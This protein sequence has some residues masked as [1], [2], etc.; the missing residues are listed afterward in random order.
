MAAHTF[1]TEYGAKWHKAVAK[2]VDDLHL[3]SAFY[4]YPPSTGSTCAP[5]TRSSQISSWQL[6]TLPIPTSR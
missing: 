4:D 5:P 1:A 2:I 6:E 3:L